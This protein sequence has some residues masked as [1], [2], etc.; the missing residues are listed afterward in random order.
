MRDAVPEAIFP[1][2]DSYPAYRIPVPIATKPTK[3]SPI[4]EYILAAVVASGTVLVQPSLR[5]R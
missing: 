2:D 1:E 3:R 5:A 4:D